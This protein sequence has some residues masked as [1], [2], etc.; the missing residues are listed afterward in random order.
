M[1]VAIFTDLK[2]I[3]DTLRFS[4]KFILC[5]LLLIYQ[6]VSSNINFTEAILYSCIS[7][8][9]SSMELFDIIIVYRYIATTTILRST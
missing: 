3:E 5:I 1:C 6:S 8:I 9:L 2:H 4:I 7:Y